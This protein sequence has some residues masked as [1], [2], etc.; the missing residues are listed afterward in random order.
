MWSLFFK[1]SMTP[2]YQFIDRN[3]H[4]LY[5]SKSFISSRFLVLFEVNI[6]FKIPSGLCTVTEYDLTQKGV[7]E[8]EINRLYRT[9]N[10]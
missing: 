5:F 1:T 6:R 4:F 10:F 7:P 3:L 9:F 8:I 2:E